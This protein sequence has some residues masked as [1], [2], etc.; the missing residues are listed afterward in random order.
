MTTGSSAP[1]HQKA[2]ALSVVGFILAIVTPVVGLVVSIVALVQ[3]KRS[4]NPND[5]LALGG[6][7]IGAL[8]TVGL[9]FVVAVGVKTGLTY[10]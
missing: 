5:G 6:V 7:V 4:G 1:A 3:V 2:P 8:L 10:Q 9:A